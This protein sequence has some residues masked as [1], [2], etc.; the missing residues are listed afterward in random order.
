MRKDPP[1]LSHLKKRWI[2]EANW[3]LGHY[4]DEYQIYTHLGDVEARDIIRGYCPRIII[5]LRKATM[6]IDGKE[7]ILKFNLYSYTIRFSYILPIME[8]IQTQNTNFTPIHTSFKW[9]TCTLNLLYFIQ[10]HIRLKLP[11]WLNGLRHCRWLFTD[12]FHW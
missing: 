9:C 7:V 4:K 1:V 5:T 6:L 8:R 3:R 10:I 11:W 2:E 12:S